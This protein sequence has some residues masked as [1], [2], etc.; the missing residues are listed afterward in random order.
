MSGCL[1]ISLPCW[2]HEILSG[3]AVTVSPGPTSEMAALK[4][5][6]LCFRILSIPVSQ[7]PASS[8]A[9]LIVTESAVHLEASFMVLVVSVFQGPASWMGALKVSLLCSL[10][11]ALTFPTNSH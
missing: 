4:V 3:I 2:K 5:S 7:E 6:Q 1:P 10:K 9:T 11:Q 8:M